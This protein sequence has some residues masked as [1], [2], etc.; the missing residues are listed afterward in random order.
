MV[1]KRS[2]SS[3]A[4]GKSRME[5]EQTSDSRGDLDNT[6]SLEEVSTGISMKS[7]MQSRHAA[8]MIKPPVRSLL[9]RS[10]VETRKISQKKMKNILFIAALNKLLRMAT[11]RE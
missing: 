10:Q 3:H 4:T 2:R 8:S 11:M 1:K 5:A 9:Q 6:A 7:G